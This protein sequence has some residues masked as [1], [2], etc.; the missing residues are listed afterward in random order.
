MQ[1]DDLTSRTRRRNEKRRE[2]NVLRNFEK[3]KFPDADVNLPV[4]GRDGSDRLT[5]TAAPDILI[6][7]AGNDRL[8]GLA[9]DD[10]INGGL[11]GPSC[12]SG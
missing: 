3:I 7:F 4:L 12:S 11:G 1:I 6:E 2:I 8:T 10:Q 9:G 5:G